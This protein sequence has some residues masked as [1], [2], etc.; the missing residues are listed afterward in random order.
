MAHRRPL[1]VVIGPVTGLLSIIADSL[2]R[3]GYEVAAASTHTQA[4]LMVATRDLVNFLIALVPTPDEEKHGAY[5]QLARERNL[6]LAIVVMLSEP[7]QATDDIPPTAV[8]LVKP[9]DGAELS[10]AIDDAT[11][12]SSPS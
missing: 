10:R 6:A 12:P 3:R 9:F 11:F 1:A 5:L 2:T 7:D 4:P 8:T